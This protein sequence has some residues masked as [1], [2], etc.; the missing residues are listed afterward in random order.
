VALALGVIV[1]DETVATV[2]VA[3]A[4]IAIMGGYL[5]SRAKNTTA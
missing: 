2:Q 1:L 3:G 5:I 4:A